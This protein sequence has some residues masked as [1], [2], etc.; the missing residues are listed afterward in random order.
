MKEKTDDKVVGYLK[1]RGNEAELTLEVTPKAVILKCWGY[2]I[3][4]AGDRKGSELPNG[5]IKFV[6][7]DLN[8]KFAS[9]LVK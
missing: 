2:K 8:T 1:H 7:K 3:N 4:K 5:W 6:K 9:L